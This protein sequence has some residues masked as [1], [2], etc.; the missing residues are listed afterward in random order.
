MLS[1]RQWNVVSRLIRSRLD[2]RIHGIVRDSLDSTTIDRFTNLHQSESI[3]DE[4]TFELLRERERPHIMHPCLGQSSNISA[5]ESKESHC[6]ERL[7]GHRSCEEAE[8]FSQS[9][10]SLWFFVDLKLFAIWKIDQIRF[11]LSQTVSFLSSRK[12]RR[13]DPS[14]R[15][16]STENRSNA[17]RFRMPK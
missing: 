1:F 12:W 13:V 9:S 3:D 4:K 5:V 2:D 17:D 10:S 7:A 16:A 8:C 15:T 11:H 6:S 14:K